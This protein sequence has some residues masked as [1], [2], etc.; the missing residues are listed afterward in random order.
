MG[1]FDAAVGGEDAP[2]A[3]AEEPVEGG[4]EGVGCWGRTGQ[5]REVGGVVEEVALEEGAENVCG[6]EEEGDEG[7]EEGNGEEE[8]IDHVG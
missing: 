1:R 5:E 4:G 3:C 2:V 7:E 8:V 6:E